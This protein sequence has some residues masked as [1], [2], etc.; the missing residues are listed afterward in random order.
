MKIK[1]LLNGRIPGAY[2]KERKNAST[3]L[4]DD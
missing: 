2:L 1:R 4:R 3:K